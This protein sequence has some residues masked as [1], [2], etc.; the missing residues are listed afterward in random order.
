MAPELNEST[1]DEGIDD[2]EKRGD[3]ERNETE[4]EDGSEDEEEEVDDYWIIDRLSRQGQASQF[5]LF[6]SQ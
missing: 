3:N 4:D 5:L 2:G 6:F 1:V